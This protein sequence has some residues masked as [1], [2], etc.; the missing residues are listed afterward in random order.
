MKPDRWQQI[1]KLYHSAAGAGNLPSGGAF[2]QEACAGDEDM[3]QEVESLLAH[4]P[5]A[6]SFIEARAL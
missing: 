5:Q 3:R 2:L 1:E 6:E 4:Q